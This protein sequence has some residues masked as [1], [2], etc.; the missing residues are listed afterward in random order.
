MNVV[1]VGNAVKSRLEELKSDRP[2]GIYV[3]PV[4]DQSAAV[5]Q[6]VNEFIVN[7]FVSIAIVIVVLLFTMGLKSA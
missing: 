4:Y 1:D 7:L 3:E 5:D 6:S 2:L